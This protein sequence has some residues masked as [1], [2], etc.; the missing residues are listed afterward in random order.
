MRLV[1]I[2]TYAVN[3]LIVKGAG[4]VEEAAY[5]KCVLTSSALRFGMDM[6]ADTGGRR[7]KKK[8]GEQKPQHWSIEIRCKTRHRS[9]A[10]TPLPLPD[11]GEQPPPL[12][13]FQCCCFNVTVSL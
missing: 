1:E 12:L 9:I 10:A 6:K 8:S 2:S 11:G 3:T 7:A 4:S 13:L 5:L